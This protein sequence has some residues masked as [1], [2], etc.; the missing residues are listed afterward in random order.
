M[1]KGNVNNET[2]QALINYMHE[3][4]VSL[5]RIATESGI[6]QPNLH[7]FL[8]GKGLSVMNIERLWKVIGKKRKV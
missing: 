8:N 2:R 5:N 6:H 4:G 1:I 3:Y 7:V